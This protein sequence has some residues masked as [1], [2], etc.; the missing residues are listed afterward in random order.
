MTDCATTGS[1]AGYGVEDGSVLVRRIYRSLAATDAEGP[2]TDGTFDRLERAFRE[3]FAAE[4]G[5]DDLPEPV[6]LALEDALYRTREGYLGATADLRT[7]LVTDFYRDLAGYHCAY[8][9][10]R[11]PAFE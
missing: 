2:Y 8:T 9:T 11:A 3:A 10:R 7:A 6:A 4:T 5:L 1:F